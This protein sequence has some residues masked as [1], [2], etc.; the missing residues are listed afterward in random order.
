MIATDLKRFPMEHQKRLGEHYV[1]LRQ[2]LLMMSKDWNVL[3]IL[4]AVVLLVFWNFVMKAGGV[5][6]FIKR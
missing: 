2:V 4:L 6:T 5:D 1:S 3:L